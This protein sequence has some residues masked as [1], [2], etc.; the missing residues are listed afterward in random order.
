MR[1]RKI[2]EKLLA[3]FLMAAVAVTMIPSG[4]ALSIDESQAA[5][6]YKYTLSRPSVTINGHKVKLS[7][8]AISSLGIRGTCCKACTT[9][10]KGK[11][12][13]RRLSN[14]D[15][16]V[17]LM[18]YYGYQKGY[19]GQT[20]M[21]G[22]LLGRAMSWAGGRKPTWPVTVAQI[23][24]YINAM[25]ASVKVPNRFEC[26]YCDPTNGSQEFIAYKMNPP[27]HITLRKTSADARSMAAGS[28]Y[29]FEGIE[30]TV[31]D[32]TGAVAGVLTCRANGTT[33][34]LTVDTGTYTVKETKTNQ[35]YKLNSREYKQTLTSGQTWNVAAS[36][37]PKTGTVR[38]KK[39]VMGHYDGGLAF[40]FRLTNTANSSITYNVKTDAK[41]GEV[42]VPVLKGTYR[43]EE[44]L[45]D[46][47]ELIDMTGIQKAAVGIG[48]TYT[49]ERENSVSSSGILQVR[50]TTND[51]GGTAGYK[52]KITG[53]LYNQGELT[54]ST[55]LKAAEPSV[56]GYD[57]NVY[58]LEDWTVLKEDL[59]ELNK[60]AEE[61]KT[62][63]KTVRIKSALKNKSGSGRS[64][65]EI[66]EALSVEET[67]GTIS[68]GTIISDDGKMY[69]AKEEVAFAVVFSEGEPKEI[70]AKKT[71]DNIREQFT[72]ES[73]EEIGS[74]SVELTEE[75]T[76]NLK[77]VEYVYNSEKPG[78]SAYETD[79]EKQIKNK[80]PK[81]E[82]KD[83]CEITCADFDWCGSATVY[84]EIRDGEL[85]GKTESIVETE[86]GGL[87]PAVTEGITCG[88][89]TVE[90]VMTDAQKKQY[91]QPKE[92]TKE[93]TQKDKA[94]V[95]L[96]NFEN[97]ARWTDTELVKT[98][99][100]GNISGI[101]FRL[102]GKNNSGE[103][104]E[105]EAV[106]DSDGKIDFGNLY[107]GEYIISEK[108]FDPDKY[109]NNYRVEGYDVPAQKLV[110]TGDEQEKVTVKFDNVPLRSLYLTKVDEETQLFLKN[111]VFDLLEGDDQIAQFRIVLDDYGCAGI[112]MIRCDESSGIR[113]NKPQVTEDGEDEE[114]GPSGAEGADEDGEIT[115]VEPYED[116]KQEEDSEEEEE[117]AQAD[118]N[119]AV[120]K[121]LKEGKTYTLK[122]VAAPKGYAPS[123]NYSFTFEDGQKL[124]LEN[125]SP[126]IGTSA[127]DK[128]T[129]IH[130]S[131][132]EGKVTIIDTVTY[133]NLEPGHKYLMSGVLALRP[134][135]ERTE[136]EQERD[137]EGIE[138]VKDAKGKEV[139]AQKEFVPKSENGT[140]N[141]EFVFDAS[142]LDGK[143]VVA[144]EQLLDP[145][146]NDANGNVTVLASHEDMDDEAQSIYFPALGTKAIANDTGKNLT[147]AD[148]EVTITDTV[149]YSNVNAGKVYVLKGTLMDK[150]TGKPLR[151]HGAEITSS[152]TFRAEKEGPV[153]A[154]EGEE[155][156]E[157]LEEG[158]SLVSGT[159]EMPF[160]FDGSD[161]VGKRAVAFEKLYTGGSLVG[162]HSD[163]NDEAQ[164]VYLPA[165]ETTAS[166]N[167]V[168]MITDKVLYRNLLEGETYIMNG[169]L[170]DKSTG[171]EFVM[172]GTPVT[173]QMDFVPEKKDGSIVMEFPVPVDE[174]EGKTLVAFET[175]SIVTGEDGTAIEIVNHRDINNKAQ[176]VSFDV[177]QTGQAEP[178]WILIPVGFLT[179]A[180]ISLLLRRLRRI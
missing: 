156:S 157:R 36:D 123:V 164:T 18:Y 43:C 23:K 77:P 168:D 96:Y 58:A 125:A 102:E 48:E 19:L 82:K 79:L 63:E 64:I 65:S 165:I 6:A 155:L 150:E 128:D 44:I 40:N 100:D 151:S 21:N 174:L 160:R 87:S 152:I 92:Q 12:T 154:E 153:F 30:Y 83:G 89:F 27:A 120:L 143:Q 51:G 69:R 114:A 33:N 26:Y 176:T 16:R 55:I 61:R 158:V 72:G 60:A 7:I 111:A 35:W 54:E 105:R 141:I 103:T 80:R 108:D 84:Q 95:F 110:I 10:K 25:P 90:E 104:V 47:T 22:F 142:L 56:S 41:T 121:G 78:L 133:S 9:A 98:S 85:T 173:A 29:S 70:D 149:D 169:V 34:T 167:G 107:A 13:V 94:A 170:M 134:T 163:I 166:T 177:P 131:D 53:E 32:S 118:Y 59:V 37:S 1:R 116:G 99:S 67:E 76:V 81:T 49:F 2:R 172:N 129:K 75:V 66:V 130:M 39:S 115:I 135:G 126:Q 146:L 42:N 91:R 122:E 113:A 101:T 38:I 145:K 137:A 162:E 17:K 171:E 117:T 28:G 179:A 50:K 97:E 127:V 11:A 109:E 147:E 62:G 161:L 71:G 31:Y 8:F 139:T 159:V 136:E 3:V 144:M 138:V 178:W 57:E 180:A 45:P 73:F 14:T 15:L 124:V 52:F 119:F 5:T 86:D 4:V 106:T 132:A 68:K 175:C 93:I 148:G 20:N 46:N 140:V 88:R 74:S 24:K 112:D